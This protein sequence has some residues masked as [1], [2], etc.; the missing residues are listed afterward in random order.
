MAVASSFNHIP[1]NIRV[2]LFYAEVDGS[3]A[4]G[5]TDNARSLLI[6]GMNAAG[7]SATAN[8]PVPVKSYAQAVDLFGNGSM[9][10]HMCDKY[11]SNDLLGELW[12]VPLNDTAGTANTWDVTVTGTAGLDGI[13]YLY[14]GGRKLEIS[15]DET[16][17]ATAQAAAIAAAITADGELPV[18]AT[19]AGAVATLTSKAQCLLVQ[20]LDVRFNFAGSFGGETFPDSVTVAVVNNADG[21]TDP[22][23]GTAITNIGDTA[24]DYWVMPYVGTSVSAAQMDAIETEFGD[25]ANGRWGPTRQLYGHCFSAFSGTQGALT[26]YGNSRN[27]PHMSVIG[28]DESPTPS[29]EWAAA[30]AAVSARSL[31]IDPARPLQTLALKGV[32]APP[33]TDR[34]TITERNTLYFDG[35]ACWYVSGGKV[36][37]ERAITS[38]QT[39]AND[40]P[41]AA[42]LDIQTLATLQYILR[43]SRS[44]ITGKYGRHKLAN[45]G[46]R[47]GAG[48]P[49]VTPSV[50][51]GEMIAAYD[52][53][54]NIGLVENAADFV[55]NL[56][57]ERNAGDVN[58]I[59]VLYPPDL[60]NQFR[61]FAMLAQFR[62]Q[63]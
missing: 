58:R 29:W 4:A 53:Y 51:R 24:F 12:A 44:R 6:G 37:I 7:G 13:L 26:T 27:D 47:Y 8:I 57:V 55:D 18:T 38:Y 50:I 17:T 11:I 21:A 15:V 23:I 49:I 9:L 10:A 60:I 20:S 35:I 56:I 1:G 5:G 28:Y 33:E 16:D 54:E 61:V 14:I 32:S 59:D 52:A 63:Y 45:D 36:R 62:L 19:S 30:F 39:D 46:T 3:A 43:D 40:N 22:S 34:F 41:D 25:D 31:K 48:Q 42:F 2:P